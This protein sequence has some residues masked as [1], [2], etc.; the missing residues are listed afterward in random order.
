MTAISSFIGAALIPPFDFHRVIVEPWTEGFS[1][2][3]WIVLMGALVGTACGLVGNY[4]LLRR[5]ALVG[6]AISHSILPGLVVA[7]LIFRT[8]GTPAMF[9]GALGAGLLTVAIIE[10]IQKQS[11][12]KVDA[13][14]CI[15][16]TSLFAFGVTLVSAAEA[17]G[18]VHVDADCVLYGEIALVP[19][20][21]PLVLGGIELG[22][23]PVFR[24]AMV[25]LALAAGILVFYKE[26]LITS[27]DPGLS[28]SMGLRTGVW[29]YGLMIALS[30]VVVSAFES[31][32]AILAVAML[33]VPAMFAAQISSRLPMRLLWTT[34]HAAAS[35]V[36]GYHLSVW[37]QCSAAAA[38]VVCGAFFFALAWGGTA[39]AGRL[40][41]GSSDT[42]K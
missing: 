28:R 29:H 4:L 20:D 27:F 18:P 11:R 10:F 2:T 33:I 32:G 12:V 42:A 39:L 37:L 34:V 35:A 15:A 14:I 30:L 1:L 36:A 13:A 6:D 9:A 7:F 31:V 22:P 8:A 17:G 24:M 19:F 38:M 25:T 40:H 16:F 3:V 23:P 21:P 5:M 26:L 41:R